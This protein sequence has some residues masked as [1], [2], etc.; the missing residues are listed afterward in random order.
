MVINFKIGN[1]MAARLFL[2]S[3]IVIIMSGCAQKVNIRALEPAEID[4]A[5]KTKKIT[6]VPFEND[7]VGLSN[8]IEAN[9]V[10]KKINIIKKNIKKELQNNLNLK[11]QELLSS[12]GDSRKEL[13]KIIN[14]DFQDTDKLNK[15]IANKRKEMENKLNSEKRKNFENSIQFKERDNTGLQ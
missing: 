11:K 7:R 14:T 1:W 15:L 4:R 13:K 6:V 9:L 12:F 2:L 8:K 10:N 5:A 3:I